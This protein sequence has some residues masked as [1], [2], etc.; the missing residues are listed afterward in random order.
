MDTA[1]RRRASAER[2]AISNR[3]YKRARE[4][5]MTR[6]A[7]KYVEEYKELLRQEKERDK[8]EGVAWTS[9]DGSSHT[10]RLAH[11]TGEQKDRTLSADSGETRNNEGEK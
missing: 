7:R 11:H 10:D 5:A 8:K 2:L 3:N 1:E 4:R 6:L 9:L